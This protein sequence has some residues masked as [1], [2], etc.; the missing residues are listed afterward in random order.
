MIGSGYQIYNLPKLTVLE[1]PPPVLQ[2]ILYAIFGM[3]GR[4]G[5]V[6]QIVP[7]DR[8]ATTAENMSAGIISFSGQFKRA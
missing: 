1:Q 4:L 2:G 3:I 8:F 6:R 5:G 7:D